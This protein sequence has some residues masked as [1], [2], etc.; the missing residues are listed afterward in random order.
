[1][2]V[3]TSNALM[4]FR[5]SVPKYLAMTRQNNYTEVAALNTLKTVFGFEAFRPY[6]GSVI[7]FALKKDSLV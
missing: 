7:L 2:E 1:M 5:I 3:R 4:T 6:Q